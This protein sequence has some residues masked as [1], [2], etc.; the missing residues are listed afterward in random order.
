MTLR[1]D[2]IVGARLVVAALLA[3][4]YATGIAVPLR[5]AAP[6]AGSTVPAAAPAPDGRTH[7]QP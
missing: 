4:Y 2:P 7:P 1:T 6:E 3:L 5:T